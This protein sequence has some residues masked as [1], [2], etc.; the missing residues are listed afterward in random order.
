MTEIERKQSEGWRYNNLLLPPQTCR[1]LKSLC[2][3]AYRRRAAIVEVALDEYARHHY[4]EIAKNQVQ[5][6]HGTR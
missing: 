4:P 2:Q 3:A 1:L 6:K 5:T